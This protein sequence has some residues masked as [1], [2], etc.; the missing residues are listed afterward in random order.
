M[1][2]KQ[3]EEWQS[4]ASRT[5]NSAACFSLAYV[6]INYLMW[7]VTGLVGR[8]FKFDTFV[9]YYGVKMILNGQ[10]WDKTKIAAVYSAGPLFALFIALLC[11]FLYGRLRKIRTL[12][13]VF[14]L[15]VFVIGIG[16][17]LSH[18]IMA[19]LG[20]YRYNSYYYQGFAVTFA[21]L[22]VPKFL[23]Y[24]LTVFVAIFIVYFGTNIGRLFLV[25]SYSYSKVN[26]L[27]KRRKYFFETAIA[28]FI[29]GAL[30][31]TIAVFPK[32]KAALGVVVLLA[33]THI[34]YF[35]VIGMILAVGSFSLAY[36]EITRPE[37]VRYKSLQTPNVF[38]VLFTIIAWV[39]V[40]IT[41]RGVYF[42]SM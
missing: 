16:I 28:P 27:L 39:Y 20:I 22:K 33:A 2:R 42:S 13:N 4:R 18:L 38:F 23:V 25:F 37:L 6:L 14:L 8:L 1:D 31:S 29:L 41:F 30:V 3:S 26:N 11:L 21:W 36:I 19:A 34:I 40:Y 24:L 12:L 17:F 32:D 10:V 35:T 9:Y 5:V 7:I 15:W